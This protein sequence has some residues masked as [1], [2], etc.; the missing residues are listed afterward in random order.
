MGGLGLRQLVQV[1]SS[2]WSASFLKAALFLREKFPIRLPTI[3]EQQTVLA[4]FLRA[5]HLN[6]P[7]LVPLVEVNN[8]ADAQPVLSYWSPPLVELPA[9]F[10]IPK[11][12][13]LVA[14][15]DAANKTTLME[16][17]PSRAAKAWLISNCCP[18]VGSW[19]YNATT[20]KKPLHVIKDDFIQAVG[21]RLL[22]PRYFPAGDVLA[23]HASHCADCHADLGV[24]M[25]AQ[26][27]MLNIVKR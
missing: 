16:R 10:K 25:A 14:K 21:V 3:Q 9:D 15:I 5:I 24:D 26:T 27:L 8:A 2:A 11:Q 4:P 7:D 13:E 12:S 6:C 19:L 20:T 22:L 23:V 18:G 1:H 17:I